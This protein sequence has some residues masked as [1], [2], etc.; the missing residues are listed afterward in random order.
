MALFLVVDECDA[1]TQYALYT[2]QF[3]PINQQAAQSM[4]FADAKNSLLIL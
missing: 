4:A 3:N 1:S 2:N